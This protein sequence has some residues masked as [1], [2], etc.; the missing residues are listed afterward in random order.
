MVGFLGIDPNTRVRA[1][2]DL[3]EWVPAA[4]PP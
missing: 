4:S 1:I 2:E 3:A